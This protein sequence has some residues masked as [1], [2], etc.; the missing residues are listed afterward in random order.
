[1]DK[2][3]I[4]GGAGYIGSH[5]IHYLISR[6]IRPEEI[7]VFDNL[8]YG[9]R[10]FVP[11]KVKFY[12]GDLLNKKDIDAVFSAN[13]IRT[14]IHFAGYAYVGESM[15]L[16]G[17]Y[18]ENNVF[19][20]L[21]LLEAMRATSCKR[22][23]FSSSCSTYGIPKNNPI[24]ESAE[25]VPI[26]PYGESKL[27]FERMLRWYGSI[28]G[29]RSICLRYFNAAGA[30]YGIGEHHDP[31]THLVPLIMQTA[32]GEREAA[33]IYGADYG[34]PDGT[35][36]RDYIHVVDL[37]EAHYQAMLYFDKHDI[38]SDAFN[39]GTG[40]GVSVRQVVNRAKKITGVDFK[41]IEEKRRSGDPEIL[42]A[43]STKA[44]AMLDWQPRFG[45]EDILSSA[46]NWHKGN[47]FVNR[48]TRGRLAGRNKE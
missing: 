34:T 26:N 37:A 7:I 14:V 44:N 38:V 21:N 12:S 20:G 10:E 39:L 5:T 24:R 42:V 33:H 48:G 27:M 30:A 18:F 2:I 1:M 29:L 28:H 6:G 36:I 9:H 47:L 23:I 45:I 16:P 40:S 43:E 8:V 25:Q 3:L 19:G 15:Q 31:E 35:C 4:T 22:I 32:N 41:V 46:W 13:T 17:K 11:D